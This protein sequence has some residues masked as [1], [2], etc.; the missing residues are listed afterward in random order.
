MLGHAHLRSPRNSADRDRDYNRPEG[1]CELTLW[2]SSIVRGLGTSAGTGG[3]REPLRLQ[4]EKVQAVLFGC[5]L[6]G[7]AVFQVACRGGSSG[8]SP[9]TLAGAYTIPVM[10]TSSA[11]TGSLVRSTKTTLQVQ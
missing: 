2:S 6:F 8:G 3:R 10:G 7:G 11:S 5:V 9:G 4:A 1:A